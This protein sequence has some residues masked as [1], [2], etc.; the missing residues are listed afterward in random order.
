MFGR[1]LNTKN[2]PK[3]RDSKINAADSERQENLSKDR[4]PSKGKCIY[5]KETGHYVNQCRGFLNLNLADQV[6]YISQNQACFNCLGK[7]PLK[8]CRSEKNM[9]AMRLPP[10]NL[11]S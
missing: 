1:R 11:T 2:K 7:H 8:D 5:C 10:S 3:Y 4:F 6:S 9:L